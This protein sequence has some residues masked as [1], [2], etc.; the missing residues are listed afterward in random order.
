MSKYAQRM[1]TMENAANIIKSLFSSMNDPDVI[2]FGGGAIAKE[3]LPVD[4]IREITADIMT[5]EGRGYETLSYG[6]VL[7]V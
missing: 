5:V 1:K 7:G 6:P 2:S 3:C 4:K